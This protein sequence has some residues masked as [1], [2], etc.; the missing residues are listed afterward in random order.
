MLMLA[1]AG[2]ASRTFLPGRLFN[3]RSFSTASS[4]TATSSSFSPSAR[5]AG[6]VRLDARNTHARARYTT[7]RLARFQ[8]RTRFADGKSMARP[9]QPRY[10]SRIVCFSFSFFFL[11]SSFSLL[12][13]F[14]SLSRHISRR[15]FRDPFP[16]VAFFSLTVRRL[17]VCIS[18]ATVCS[19]PCPCIYV[20]VSYFQFHLSFCSQ[21]Q[22][23]FFYFFFSLSMMFHL[24]S[25]PR[26]SFTLSLSLSLSSA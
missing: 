5:L 1:G 10:A 16:F 12:S 6:C 21:C 15:L 11:F 9:F 19:Y 4:T 2:V 3:R 20:S 13:F 17:S 23:L 18:S 24:N 7:R 8:T 22:F 26:V 14:P 25:I